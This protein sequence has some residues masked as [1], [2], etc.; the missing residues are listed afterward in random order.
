MRAYPPELARAVRTG[1]GEER[2]FLEKHAPLY[3]DIEDLQELRARVEDTLDPSVVR[4]RGFFDPGAVRALIDDW[5]A[6]FPTL[7]ATLAPAPTK[8]RRSR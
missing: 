7:L 8:K 4:R 1:D 5:K 6:M 3:V 2:R